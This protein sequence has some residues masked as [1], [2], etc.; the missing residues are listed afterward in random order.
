MHT[1]W[2][3]IDFFNFFLSFSITF[4][5]SFSFS[6]SFYFSFSFLISPS[7]SSS[8][9]PSPPPPPPPRLSS[10][11][12]PLL[13]PSSL[14]L[15]FTRKIARISIYWLTLEDS[16]PFTINELTLSPPLPL[17]HPSPNPKSHFFYPPQ[18]PKNYFLITRLFNQPQLT[19]PHPPP[20]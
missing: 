12:E 5:F 8:P 20:P 16:S 10:R 4:S 1:A 13:L 3:L 7:S 14:L 19:T 11:P 15:L 17:L 9:S 18:N 2:I 6:F